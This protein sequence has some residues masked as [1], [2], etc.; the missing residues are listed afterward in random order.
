MKSIIVDDEP[1]SIKILEKYTATLPWLEVAATCSNAIEAMDILNQK[2][3]DLIFLDI[4][5]PQMSGLSL[6]K[7]LAH[8]P[9]VI[10]TTAYSE[11]AVEGFELAAVDYL[12]KPFSLE[13][14]LKAVHRAKSQYDNQQNTPSPLSEHL[15]IKA[16]KKLFKIDFDDI[17]Y[18]QAY[19]DYVKVFTKQKM[20]LS[21]GRLQHI[22]EQLPNQHFQR[23]HRSYIIG[24]KAIEFIE[25][26]LVKIGG[27]KLPIAQ[28]YREVLMERL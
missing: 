1:I 21:K 26:N 19:G 4:N 7:S 14:F 22:E 9:L 23:I 24:L 8:P 20:L 25:G 10:F 16:D 27:E 6:L 3:I 13:R 5:M 2:N 28:T 15:L 17:L 11:H 18:L 12:L